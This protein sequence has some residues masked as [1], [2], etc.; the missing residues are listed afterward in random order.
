MSFGFKKKLLPSSKKNAIFNS[1]KEK[2]TE[3]LAQ[4]DQSRQ[5]A[6]SAI[7]YSN[8][9]C[10]N[11]DNEYDEDNNGNTGELMVVC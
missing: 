1:A 11:T 6:G 5:T 3:G 9:G 2:E 8:P 7:V 4:H 10:L